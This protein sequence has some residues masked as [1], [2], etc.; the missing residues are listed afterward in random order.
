M[1]ARALI[2]SLWAGVALCPVSAAAAPQAARTDL[3]VARVSVVSGD[4]ATRRGDSGDWIAT[5]VNSAIVEGDSVRTAGASRAEVQLS[6]GNFIRVV[7]DSEAQ[8]VELGEK[9]FRVRVIHGTALYSEL[10]DSPADIDIETPFAAVRPQEKGRYRIHVG[11]DSTVI[12]VREGRTEIA[13]EH[14]TSSLTKGQAMTLWQGSAGVE[15][16][17]GRASD[18]DGFDRWAANRDRELRRSSAY[19][20]VSRDIYGVDTFDD[21]GS[22][23]HVSSVGHCWFPR[24][25]ATWVPYRHGHWTWID[26]Y[27]WNWVPYAPWGWATSHWGRWHYDP[28]WGWGWYPGSPRLRHIWRPALVSFIGAAIRGATFGHIGWVPLAPGELYWPWYGRSVYGFGLGRSAV[29]NTIV[30][31]NSVNIITNYRYARS[32][33]GGSAVSYLEA[34]QFGVAGAN[35]PRGMRLAQSARGVA[36]RG[37]LPVVPSRASQGRVLP[38]SSS[39]VRV[40]SPRAWNRASVSQLRDGTARVSFDDQR[41]YLRSSVDDFQRRYDTRTAAVASSTSTRAGTVR[42]VAERPVGTAGAQT[43]R[44]QAVNP[45]TSPLQSQR[46]GVGAASATNRRDGTEPASPST[47]VAARSGTLGPASTASI[48]TP[49]AG[50]VVRGETGASARTSNRVPAVGSNSRSRSAVTTARAPQGGARTLPASPRVSSQTRRQSSASSSASATTSSRAHGPVFAPRNGSRVGVGGNARTTLRTSRQG[51]GTRSSSTVGTS[52]PAG[53]TSARTAS[54]ATRSSSPSRV[55]PSSPPAVT[56]SRNGAGAS[57]GQRSSSAAGAARGNR[58]VQQGSGSSTRSSFPARTRSRIGP[59]SSSSGGSFGAPRS[60]RST[61]SY[62]RPTV[63]ATSSS[64]SSRIGPGT[65]S[66]S[67]R[68]SPSGVSSRSSSRTSS[69]VSPRSPSGGGSFGTGSG[70]SAS[71]QS[72]SGGFGSSRG[73]RSTPSYRRPTVGAT[74]S[75]R[76]S[77]TGPSSSSSSRARSTVGSRSSSSGASRSSSSRSARPSSSSSTRRSSQSPGDR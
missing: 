68:S 21:H 67:R 48:R 59:G 31:D 42:A 27:G 41:K 22:W 73:Q 3:G 9:V 1:Q 23:R 10:P 44:E 40:S 43:R 58:G 54:P 71:R 70:R 74:S 18:R 8:F 20:Y 14:S 13:M 46:R 51:V 30:V 52:R 63:G 34:D 24:V 19:R 35:T 25:P 65:S 6:P 72:S 56:G 7:A 4:V 15:F 62:R 50:S 38:G 77:R 37:P 64:R 5:T 75:S 66:S 32:G 61:P 16:E 49:T 26:Y 55:R 76:S 33:P 45:S 53:S 36:I 29:G 2:V 28:I 60:Q 11:A 47:A 39:S 57:P 17:V 12:E 69:R